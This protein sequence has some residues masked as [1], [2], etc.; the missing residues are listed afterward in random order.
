MKFGSFQRS[1]GKVQQNVKL[2]SLQSTSDHVDPI[3]QSPYQVSL[4]RWLAG[5]L[6]GQ[7]APLCSQPGQ[8]LHGN[9]SPYSG[10]KESKAMRSIQT[11]D[12]AGRPTPLQH[13][14]QLNFHHMTNLGTR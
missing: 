4:A 13:S 11:Q 6:P 9:I 8:V 2:R 5:P 14:L 7:S 10:K 12:P 1:Q 3:G